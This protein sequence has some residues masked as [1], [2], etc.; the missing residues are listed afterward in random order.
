[1][2]S[3][4]NRRMRAPAMMLAAGAVVAV[5]VGIGQG[6]GAATAVALVVVMTAAVVFSYRAGGRDSGFGAL[7]G[8]RADER[9]ALIRTR[10]RAESRTVMTAA[11]VIGVLIEIA[12]GYDHHLGI[13]W[14]CQLLIAVGAVTNSAGLRRHGARG[15]HEDDPGLGD[16]IDQ[17]APAPILTWQGG[18]RR[19]KPTMKP[20]E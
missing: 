10:A 6:L 8:G 1:M 15:E 12:L 13:A 5:A 4:R 19:M 7:I 11:A 9:Q 17:R 14:S 3:I 20:T 16:D 18:N 2:T